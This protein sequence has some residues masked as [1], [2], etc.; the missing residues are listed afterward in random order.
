V[1]CIQNKINKFVGGR[2]NSFLAGTF[3]ALG[4]MSFHSL[5]AAQD[6]MDI[7]TQLQLSP[8]T[9]NEFS[10]GVAIKSEHLDDPF[11]RQLIIDNFDRLTAEYE[12]K[13][14]PLMQGTRYD[15]SSANKLVEFSLANGIKL[16]GHTLIW[17]IDYPPQL[18]QNGKGQRISKSELRNRMRDH[19][20]TTVNHFRGAVDS[21]DVVN[22]AISDDRNEIYRRSEFH[23][24]YGDQSY[25][26]DAFRFTK[27]AD[28]E[29]EL[30]YNDYMMELPS[31]RENLRELIRYL[32]SENVDLTGIGF[33]GHYSLEWPPVELIE[34]AFQVVVQENLKI[35]IS[36][37]DVTIYNDY[38]NGI[39]QPEIEK[40]CSDRIL[41][42]QARRYA[43]LFALFRKYK[44][45][46]TDITFWGLTDETSWL[47]F[48]VDGRND[49]PLLFDRNGQPKP[50]YFAILRF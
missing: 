16:T 20:F 32:K 41:E 18:F 30:W 35:K 15:F 34:E 14:G 17:H 3:L 2:M 28:P 26:V 1:L 38:P 47:N 11:R 29:V 46:I 9:G 27:Q 24:I 6:K 10:L 25:I 8:V 33:Q 7:Q 31:K 23:Q 22:E 21:W 49:C 36:E 40:P 44:K 5:G 19:I 48:V 39:F 45:H 37:L 12:M 13:W 4:A 42:A 50:A 43:E